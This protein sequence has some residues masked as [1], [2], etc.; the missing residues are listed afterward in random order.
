[1]DNK[2]QSL[3]RIK[4]LMK[5]SVGN[6]LSENITVLQGKL[7][8]EDSMSAERMINAHNREVLGADW[9]KQKSNDPFAERRQII[10]IPG[11]NNQKIN[12]VEGTTNNLF[13]SQDDSGTLFAHRGLKKDKYGWYE[14][15]DNTKVYYPEK[16]FWETV[17][18]ST[19]N[20]K[21]GPTVSNP[22]G[23]SY[24]FILNL[25]DNGWSYAT[26]G[27][28]QAINKASRGWK[29]TPWYYKSDGDQQIPYDESTIDTRDSFDKFW[30]E[31][32]TAIQ[33]VGGIA[34][35]FLTAGIGSL[36]TAAII[37]DAGIIAAEGA[38]ILSEVATV[39]NAVNTGRRWAFALEV[40]TE[41]AVN[42]PIGIY[43]EGRQE[44]SGTMSFVFAALPFIKVL[45]GFSRVFNTSINFTQ[46]EIDEITTALDTFTNDPSVFKTMSKK[47][48]Q[49]FEEVV[50]GV[51]KNPEGF[52]KLA[53]A[54]LAEKM[55]K[56]SG[57]KQFSNKVIN[58]TAIMGRTTYR[59]VKHIA[60]TGGKELGL[61]IGLEKMTDKVRE[62]W[63]KLLLSYEKKNGKEMPEEEIKRISTE[64]QK[65]PTEE[66]Q[67]KYIEDLAQ[68]IDRGNKVT[69]DSP[70]IS[71]A[72]EELNIENTAHIKS[73]GIDT[74][75]AKYKNYN[76]S[77]KSET[78][79][80]VKDTIPTTDSG[81]PFDRSN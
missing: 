62:S 4:L 41:A 5:Y 74:M 59:T 64:V 72:T 44:G 32:G 9:D 19:K 13:T 61:V 73:V 69:S 16:S 23:D 75:A 10:S 27:Y 12:V 55:S 67:V 33:I 77:K 14:V 56:A 45:P 63:D 50:K 24:H 53:E 38:L 70:I 35:G 15:R 11:F 40:I 54:A 8:K 52:G 34:L 30:D 68:S 60:T 37:A 80:P 66:E 1:M 58:W 2:E 43:E 22:N 76:F 79:Q 17:V 7:L 42:I 21:T 48:Q 81:N 25:D 49:V 3:D 29:I 20:F 47:S 26:I 51:N 28:K 6:T 65:L 78:T 71:K 18:G 46:K 39:V 36:I 57:D 31:N